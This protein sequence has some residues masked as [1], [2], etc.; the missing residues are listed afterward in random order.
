VF[1][2]L[3]QAAGGE[4][5]AESKSKHLGDKVGVKN[6]ALFFIKLKEDARSGTLTIKNK[7]ESFLHSFSYLT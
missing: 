6:N 4:E 2:L 3:Q 7:S 1:G 5:S